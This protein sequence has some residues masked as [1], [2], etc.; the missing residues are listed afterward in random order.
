[1]LRHAEE[2]INSYPSG[3]GDKKVDSACIRSIYRVDLQEFLE[4]DG[5]RFVLE[6]VFRTDDRDDVSA[7]VSR[8]T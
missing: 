3:T 2:C 5:A 4:L 6:I 7:Q 8:A 1:M